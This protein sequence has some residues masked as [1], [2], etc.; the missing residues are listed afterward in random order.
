[1]KLFIYIGYGI[2]F[3]SIPLILLVALH[4]PLVQAI[5]LFFVRV[6][7]KLRYRSSGRRSGSYRIEAGMDMYHMSILRLMKYPRR[8][9]GAAGVCGA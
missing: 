2:N 4:R 3:L 8:I 7:A 9:V 1:M 5:I 6:G